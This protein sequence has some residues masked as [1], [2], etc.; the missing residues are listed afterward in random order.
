MISVFKQKWRVALAAVALGSIGLSGTAFA[1]NTASGTSI[2]N[3]AT[4]NY[5]VG[6]VAQTPINAAATF[7]VD[8][9]INL[10]V[11]EH[12][13]SLSDFPVTPGQNNVYTTFVVTNTGNTDEGFNL[14]V[15]DLGGA[16]ALTGLTAYVDVDND[17]VYDPGAGNDDAVSIATLARGASR[18]VFIVGNTPPTATNGQVRN[19]QLLATARVPNTLV[20][21]VNDTSLDDAM[22]VEIVVRNETGTADDAFA[23]VSAALSVA[24]T[25]TVVWDPVNF[26]SNPKAIPSARVQY[27]ITLSN[28]LGSSP[29]TLVSISDPIPANTTFAPDQYPGSR[30]VSVKVGAAPLVYC[31]AE[32]GS[33]GNNDGCYLTGGGSLSVG[34]PILTTVTNGAGNDVVVSFQVTIN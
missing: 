24:K 5:T 25:S 29:A 17:G 16:L 28:A 32:A 13:G 11:A 31:E 8:S 23:V 6:T 2:T 4:V 33:D 9:V 21:W 7:L 12:P 30:D 3:T 19:V 26:G 27:Q 20:A 34:T 14:A 18:T 22:Q 10:S 15:N 1:Q